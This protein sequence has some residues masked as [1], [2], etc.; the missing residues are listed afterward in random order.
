MILLSI[1]TS[2]EICSIAIIDD[3][4]LLAR[5]SWP[6]KMQ[7]ST[8]LHGILDQVF[9]TANINPQDVDGYA[10]G[11]GPGSFTGTRVA[12]VMGKTL[13]TASSKPLY[14]T[15]SLEMM[16]YR[17]CVNN[18]DC[19]VLSVL[20]ARIGEVYGAMYQSTLNDGFHRVD[21]EI[22]VYTPDTL[23]QHVSNHG[24]RKLIITGQL[25]E[26]FSNIKQTASCMCYSPNL[27]DAELLA[28]VSHHQATLN[29][30]L[31]AFL[32]TPCYVKQASVT[33]AKRRLVNPFAQD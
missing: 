12:V 32:L 8:R 27:P 10:V 30:T 17:L 3:S 33:I 26:E 22:G 14:G 19:M 6:H 29:T 9:D 7:L 4:R 28:E 18:P 23:C 16:A 31:D 15:D 5:T 11:L 20:K 2:A 1:E 25:T 24:D 13:A 21:T